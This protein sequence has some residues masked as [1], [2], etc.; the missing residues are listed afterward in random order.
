[1]TSNAQSQ[2]G[3]ASEKL[4]KAISLDRSQQFDQALEYYFEAL[5]VLQRI[6]I[7][8]CSP[9]QRDY[10]V[11]GIQKTNARIEELKG[12]V[13]SM[14]P[15]QAQPTTYQKT[16]NIPNN[17]ARAPAPPRN[18]QQNQNQDDGVNTMENAILMERPD[19]RF[20]D[21]AG[22][23]TAKIAL[24]EAVIMPI[25]I[26]HLYKR[27]DPWKGIL[28]YGPPGTGK[29]FLAKAVAGEAENFTF[30]TVSNA[31]LTSKWV[32]ESEKLIRNLFQLARE[33][34]P[35]VVFI[36][37]ID[38]LL[39]T[40]SSEQS[41][42]ARRMLNEF[43][44]QM[45]G[46]GSNNK[47]VLMIS[48]TNCPW[49]LDPAVRRRFE[50]RIYIPLP[51][52]ESRK[53]LILYKLK[54][55]NAKISQEN[56]NKLADKTEGFSGADISTL[57]RDALMQPLREFQTSKYFK[58]TRGI[59]KDDQERDGLWV[60]CK[61]TDEG[62]V[63]KSWSDL[64]PNDVAQVFARASHFGKSLRKIKPAANQADLAKYTE[65]TRSYGEFGSDRD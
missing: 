41:E 36:D 27:I 22:L 40:R 16:P 25:K 31:E 39:T 64:D 2:I 18:Q 44:V 45:D 49:D 55:T 43:L 4:N 28:L 47:G 63:K 5:A 33:K 62:A 50:K 14:P 11:N 57:I 13:S 35:S 65:W 19:I 53:A 48:A 3:Q 7:K 59:D 23:E 61:E 15:P 24:N 38:S 1:M 30:L 58:K 42:S 51:D 60:A 29:S 54:D 34:A 32:G 12:I 17:P 9:Q 56:I 8:Q 20:T 10:V 37:E 26:P 6:Y 52:K 21:V 46:V